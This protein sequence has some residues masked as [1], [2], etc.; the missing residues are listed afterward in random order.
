MRQFLYSFVM[1]FLFTAV[2]CYSQEQYNLVVTGKAEAKPL[3]IVPGGVLEKLGEAAG[4]ISFIS[5]IEDLSFKNEAG[6][7]LKS[8]YIDRIYYVQLTPGQIALS[9]YSVNQ[10]LLTLTLAE[11]KIDLS[12]KVFVWQIT[13]NGNK[14][15]P[16][17][18]EE[19]LSVSISSDPLGATIT[20]N[21]EDRGVTNKELHLYSGIHRLVLSKTGYA[22]TSCTIDVKREAVNK[23][24]F[25]LIRTAGLLELSIEPKDAKI[26]IDKEEISAAVPI[27][28][29]AGPHKIEI[30]KPGYKTLS[31][32][33]KI[34]QAET[35][36]KKYTLFA[37]TGSFQYV[38]SPADASTI[39]TLDNQPVMAWNG[40]KI[41]KFLPIGEYNLEV[42]APGFESFAKKIIIT[43]NNTTYEEVTLKSFARKKTSRELQ[44]MVYV[45][46][47]TFIMG[48]DDGAPNEK[49]AHEVL[50]NSFYIDRYEV[51]VL[52]YRQFCIATGRKMPKE[53]DSGWKDNEPITGVGWD[54]ASKYGEWAG[55][56]LPTEAEWEYAARGGNK[57]NSFKYSGSN[58]L[59][60]IAWYRGNSEFKPGIIGAKKPNELGV[61]DMSGNAFEWCRDWYSSNYYQKRE[62]NNPQGPSGSALKVVRGGS[63]S[64]ENSKCR[65]SA[66][67]GVDPSA[68]EGL[69]IGF[70]LVYDE[71]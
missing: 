32:I 37:K 27:E 67:D 69:P 14:I 7:Q 24:Y 53:P 44:N 43:E 10:T 64:S 23:Y 16:Q 65:I 62:K 60:E 13:I 55:K 36:K 21:D 11:S 68:A 25:N 41:E 35:I 56:R 31:E 61:F 52:E 70:R 58:N 26:Y 3:N 42:K 54:D 18:K 59:T 66:R 1:V 6:K 17:H 4:I 34:N 71:L 29:P 28:L 49:P 63:Y 39:L 33:V 48:D 46:G 19:L 22:D 9:V 38:V 2:Y 57:T 5:E 47:G 40:S 20:I 51:T 30:V 8:V 12:S 15:S 45:Q 50:V